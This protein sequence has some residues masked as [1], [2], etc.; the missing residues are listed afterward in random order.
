MLTRDDYEGP[1][2]LEEPCRRSLYGLWRDK[3]H[4][5]S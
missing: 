4:E 3:L 1:R 5:P 2:S